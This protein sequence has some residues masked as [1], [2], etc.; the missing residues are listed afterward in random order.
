[1]NFKQN[2]WDLNGFKK[3]AASYK[4]VDLFE[5]HLLFDTALDLVASK[6]RGISRD[7]SFW[8]TIFIGNSR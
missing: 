5:L 8:K 6:D 1:M 3:K 7:G 4:V 2:L